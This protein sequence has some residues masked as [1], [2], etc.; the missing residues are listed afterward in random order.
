MRRL[1]QRYPDQP[2]ASFCRAAAQR[3]HG[4]ERA[5]VAG[6]IIQALRW[7]MYRRT[8]TPFTLFVNKATTTL[9]DTVKP[10]FLA[11][12]PGM[13]ECAQGDTNNAG[14]QFRENFRRE[15]FSGNCS[16]TVPLRED[17]RR[18]DEIPQ[19][20][21]FRRRTQYRVPPQAFRIPYR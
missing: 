8:I 10:A 21:L 2:A 3:F 1:H 20:V 6:H 4:P 7:Q 12:G 17:I 16:R 9:N 14:T 15:P 19:S 11:P 5:E 13:A 18:F